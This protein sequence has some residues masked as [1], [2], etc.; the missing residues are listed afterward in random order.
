[1]IVIA[2][3]EPLIFEVALAFDPTPAIDTTGGVRYPEPAVSTVIPVITP[4]VVPAIKFPKSIT[5]SAV[6]VT[7]GSPPIK[8]TV[9]DSGAYPLPPSCTVMVATIADKIA[10]P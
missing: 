2:V 3:T 8:V 4:G 1:M 10:V 7:L 5:A 9:V 6:A